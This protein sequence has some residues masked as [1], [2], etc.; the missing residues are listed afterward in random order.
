VTNFPGLVLGPAHDR[1]NL[2]LAYR[3][4]LN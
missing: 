3:S 2:F 1:L 4:L